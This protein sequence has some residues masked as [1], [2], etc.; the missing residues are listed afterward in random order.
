M[1][2]K[3][4]QFQ[5]TILDAPFRSKVFVSAPSGAG[6]TTASVQRLAKL[7]A[8][9]NH[10]PGSILV[11]TPQR[12]MAEAYRSL[13]QAKY[14]THAVRIELAT[15]NSLVRRLVEL[16]WP[17]VADKV[18]FRNPYQTPSFLTAETSQYYL[19]KLVN[20]MLDRGC[21]ASIRLTPN[22]LFSQLID[23]LN[24]SAVVGFAH[25]QIS[26][27]LKS[28]WIGSESRLKVYDEAQLAINLFR[29]YC[30]E[31]NLLDF[32]LQ[33]E[34]F[35]KL[36][37]PNQILRKYLSA[38]YPYLVY[39]NPEEDPPYVHDIIQ[40]WLPEL[41]GAMILHDTNG[42]F[43]Q[44]LGADPI[45]ARKL[46]NSCE[47][48]IESDQTILNSAARTLI[49][50]GLIRN[51]ASIVRNELT[52]AMLNDTFELPS[53]QFRFM[54][55]MLDGAV[56]WVK[57]LIDQG[58][59]P[60][61][62]A[63]LSPFLS[64]AI[65]LAL[66]QRLSQYAIPTFAIATSSPLIHQPYTRAIV[67]MIALVIQPADG[68]AVKYDLCLAGMLLID[69][70]DLVRSALLW[71]RV[72]LESQNYLRLEIDEASQSR[73]SNVLR[74]RFEK[75]LVWLKQQDKEVSLSVMLTRFF[76]D[77]LAQPGYTAA[78]NPANA[79]YLA[80]LIESYNKFSAALPRSETTTTSRYNAEFI[81]ALR[82]GLISAQYLDDP[83]A[84]QSDSSVL[85][86]PA[87]TFLTRNRVVDYQVWLNLGSDGWYKRLEQP[88]TNPQILSRRWQPDK[89]WDADEESQFSETQIS[90][91]TSGLMARCRRRIFLGFSQY[92]E[93]GIEEQGL[94]LRRLQY[95]Y[96]L[97]KIKETHG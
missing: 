27:R 28:A 91:I 58:V 72:S 30:H 20:P 25:T 40:D 17:L 1:P 15:M 85:I 67:D 87:I 35:K 24:K 50:K 86:A 29:E 74:E 81:S 73:V 16:F 88:L 31:H 89:K 48:T 23:N 12:T 69:G 37:W 71:D 83:A 52:T 55:E 44:F 7:N 53:A 26:K 32:S 75:L 64:S 70:M 14:Q 43:Q 3:I 49:Q 97:A 68:Q 60:A 10:F 2:E 77:L 11:L 54:S 6:K 80:Q 47:Q 84:S 45:S 19:G 62:I 63:I 66:T 79:S 56:N 78:S 8:T 34:I 9:L 95:L 76:D 59:E 65:K 18:P 13:S 93:S 5:Q 51:G 94:L 41:Q 90:Q 61:Q 36:L 82:S 38:Q 42:G 46:S 92:G 21:F 4:T 57:R 33:V 22:R 39:D 96:R